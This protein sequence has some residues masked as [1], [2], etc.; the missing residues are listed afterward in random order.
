M[1]RSL[2]LAAMATALAGCVTPPTERDS[3]LARAPVWNATLTSEGGATLHGT[4]TV[5]TLLGEGRDAVPRSRVTVWVAGSRNGASH[6]WHIHRGVCGSDGPVVGPASSYPPV[7]I[8][9]AGEAQ[10]TTE[11]PFVLSERERYFA[12][13]HEAGR[14]DVGACGALVPNAAPQVLTRRM[15]QGG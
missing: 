9:G 15:R 2:V 7:P 12:H 6:P 3:Q 11:L 5:L 4:V 10:L 14:M 13:I 8:A 1:S